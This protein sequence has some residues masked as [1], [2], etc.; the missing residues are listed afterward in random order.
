[1]AS[2]P[3]AVE[4]GPTSSRKRFNWSCDAI[5]LGW[6]KIKNDLLPETLSAPSLFALLCRDL[7]S[8]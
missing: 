7:K 5:T 1:M 2:G 3:L 4:S 8:E 6:T